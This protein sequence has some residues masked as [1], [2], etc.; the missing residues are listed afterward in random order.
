[1]G[2]G[3]KGGKEVDCVYRRC[4]I[5]LSLL[6]LVLLCLSWPPHFLSF[7]LR[8]FGFACCYYTSPKPGRT[9]PLFDG[10]PGPYPLQGEQWRCSRRHV[11]HLPRPFVAI[12]LPTNICAGHNVEGFPDGR[13]AD[14]RRSGAPLSLTHVTYWTLLGHVLN[15]YRLYSRYRA[16]LFWQD[17]TMD[18]ATTTRH[19]ISSTRSRPSNFKRWPRPPTF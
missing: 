14:A 19:S 16:L 17:A 11:R 4:P 9:C 12:R 7:S 18:W 8:R 1:M 6:L 2:Q 15:W 5:L 13:L 10:S 3:G